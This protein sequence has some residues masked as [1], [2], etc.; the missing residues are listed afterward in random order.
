[1]KMRK[2]RTET[3]ERTLHFT[4]ENNNVH[5]QPK[6]LL[7][8]VGPHFVCDFLYLHAYP[9]IYVYTSRTEKPDS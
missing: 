1:M 8:P 9:H 4:D 2:P 3:V 5:P 6:V 7:C